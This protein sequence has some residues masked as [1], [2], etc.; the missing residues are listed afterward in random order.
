LTEGPQTASLHG[1]LEEAIRLGPWHIEV[2]ITPELSTR[3][4]LEAPAGTYSEPTFD[5]MSFQSPK[6]GFMRKMKRIF[7]NGLEGRSVMDCACNCGAYLLWCKELGAGECYGFDAREHWIR[8]ARFL[9]EHRVQTEGVRFEVH[10]LYDLDQVDPGHFD[11]TLFNGI[12]YHLPDPVAGL[13]LAADRTDELLIVNTATR[14]GMPDGA[15]VAAKESPGRAM[16]GVHGLNWFPSGPRVMQRILDW[17]AFPEIICSRWR[18]PPQQ[19][20]RLGRLEMLAARTPGFFGPWDAA[21]PDERAR[22]RE[23]IST[24]VPPRVTVAVVSPPGGQ[25]VELD[26]RESVTLETADAENGA[27]LP[28]RLEELRRSGVEY[29]AVPDSARD[30]LGRHPAL[31]AHMSDRHETL[32]AAGSGAW[33]VRLLDPAESADRLGAGA[34]AAPGPDDVCNPDRL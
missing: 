12:F 17:M 9:A 28:A 19:H 10:D 7:P 24:T 1:L 31:S 3:A 14:L 20:G 21:L 4:T 23:L 34:D 13:K 32:A 22:V 30:W 26:G 2:E 25:T 5:G 11:V 27:E 16:S 18:V 29:L 8:Q 33:V 15:L 6:E